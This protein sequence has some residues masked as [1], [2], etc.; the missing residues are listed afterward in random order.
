VIDGVGKVASFVCLGDELDAG[1]GCLRAFTARVRIGRRKFSDSVGTICPQN[2]C[3]SD[4]SIPT[5]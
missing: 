5:Y 1:E 4:L 3:L 2:H